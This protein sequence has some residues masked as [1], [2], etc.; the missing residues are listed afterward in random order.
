V[1]VLGVIRSLPSDHPSQQCLPHVNDDDEKFCCINVCRN[2]IV[3]SWLFEP[4]MK[5]SSIAAEEMAG[6][7]PWSVPSEL[8]QSSSSQREPR[9]R[10]STDSAELLT[11]LVDSN[12]S[13]K[14]GVRKNDVRKGATSLATLLIPGPHHSHHSSTLPEKRSVYPLD[15]AQNELMVSAALTNRIEEVLERRKLVCNIQ[16]HVRQRQNEHLRERQRLNEGLTLRDMVGE[17]G[18][19]LFDPLNLEHLRCEIPCDI[20]QD[21]AT[22]PL[23]PPNHTIPL[24]V[25]TLIHSSPLATTKGV[26]S[27]ANLTCATEQD[28]ADEEEHYLVDIEPESASSLRTCPRLL[29]ESMIQQLHDSLPDALQMNK[30][31]RCFAIGRDGDSFLTFTTH[32]A[33]YQHTLIAIKTVSGHILGG[34]ATESWAVRGGHKKGHSYYGTGQSFLFAD[35]PAVL[36]GYDADLDPAKEL[37]LYSWSGDNN[38]CQICNVDQQKLAMGGVGD[39]GLIVQEN[40]NR[41][42]TGRCQTYNNPPLTP[43]LAGQFE[44]ENFEVYGLAPLFQPVTPSDCSRMIGSFSVMMSE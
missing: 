29:T 33:P 30:W 44:I 6:S 26:E 38:Y 4:S 7:G 32:C 41:G 27:F 34:F 1:Y 15:D 10:D 21:A 12:T 14:S 42:Q 22:A 3:H 36:P 23:L 18:I 25:P 20:R 5:A 35:H 8:S 43:D 9:E 2:A 39:F 28:S 17:V 13:R 31:E 40:F 11:P 24:T 16:N 19:A 37:S